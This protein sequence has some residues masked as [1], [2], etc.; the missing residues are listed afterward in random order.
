MTRTDFVFILHFFVEIFLEIS[1]Y[2]PI[3]ILDLRAATESIIE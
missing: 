3:Q 1:L 2:K